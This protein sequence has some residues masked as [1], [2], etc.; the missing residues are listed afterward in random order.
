[1]FMAR[2][3]RRFEPI[4]GL[5]RPSSRTWTGLAIDH[6][7]EPTLPLVATGRQD[8]V[9]VASEVHGL[10]LFQCPRAP[11]NVASPT[12]LRGRVAG[13][14]AMSRCPC[15]ESAPTDQDGCAGSH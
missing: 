8:H 5:P 13:P 2:R 14:R 3:G 6:D 12:R 4:R 9:P 10:L 15:G 7:V 11:I 1:M